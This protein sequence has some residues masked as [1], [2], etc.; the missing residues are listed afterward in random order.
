M[1]RACFALMLFGAD[2]FATAWTGQ[3]GLPWS[4][5]ELLAVKAKLVQIFIKNKVVY[6][7]YMKLHP[8]KEKPDWPVFLPNAAKMLRLGF[9]DCLTTEEGGGGCNGCLN[10][11]G[12]RM[13]VEP[14]KNEVSA[15]IP[16][17]DKNQIF[18]SVCRLSLM[19]S[20]TTMALVR[21][22]TSWRRSLSTQSSRARHPC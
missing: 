15:S 2:S 1:F 21:L 6:K 12:M 19:G 4:E 20:Q 5:E 17:N 10:P 11:T 14:G 3:P 13:N 16:Q 22:Q 18:P 9:H 7:E 8:E